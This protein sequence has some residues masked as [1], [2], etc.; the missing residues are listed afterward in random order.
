[1]KTGSGGSEDIGVEGKAE[2]WGKAEVERL[3]GGPG[4]KTAGVFLPKAR[5][6]QGARDTHAVKM[7]SDSPV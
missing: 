4:R 1:M 7:P 2:I 6:T 5:L 3:L